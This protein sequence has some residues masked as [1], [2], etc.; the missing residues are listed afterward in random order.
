M[1]P[2][3][4]QSADISAIALLDEADGAGAQTIDGPWM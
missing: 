1:M 4:L 3:P 2:S